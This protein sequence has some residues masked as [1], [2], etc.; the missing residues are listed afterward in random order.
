[1]EKTARPSIKS[2][3]EKQNKSSAWVRRSTR[4]PKD[5]IVTLDEYLQ[6]NSDDDSI[7]NSESKFVDKSEDREK[8]KNN[9]EHSS[10]DCTSVMNTKSDFEYSN[11]LS[12]ILNTE[13]Q[14][15]TEVVNLVSGKRKNGRP[16]KARLVEDG[17]TDIAVDV[18][19]SKRKQGRPRKAILVEEEDEDIYNLSE[20]EMVEQEEAN[21]YL[22]DIDK[23]K[24]GRKWKSSQNEEDL[25]DSAGGAEKKKRKPRKNSLGEE[26]SSDDN[27]LQVIWNSFAG[28]FFSI[29]FNV[30]YTLLYVVTNCKYNLQLQEVFLLPQWKLLKFIFA[31]RKTKC[32]S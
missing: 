6:S 4:G 16:R 25:N 7:S 28:N 24:R 21:V 27:S 17:E 12:N 14:Q 26:G 3:I 13:S 9:G 29:V 20:I 18:G 31:A 11:G 23:R 22:K 2:K 32:M 8:V 19:A 5:L 1:M 10:L 15:E 30:Y